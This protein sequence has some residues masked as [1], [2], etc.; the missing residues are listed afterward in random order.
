MAE[1]NELLEEA[2]GQCSALSDELD[3]AVAAINSMESKA[4]SLHEHAARGAESA[5]SGARQEA[6]SDLDALAEQA[7][8]LRTD[9]SDLVLHV[10]E[11]LEELQEQQGQ[12][13]EATNESMQAMGT[14][15]SDLGLKVQETQ[16]TIATQ[17]QEAGQ[18]IDAF[19]KAVEAAQTALGE[20]QAELG[21]ALD[22]F[23]ST[24]QEKTR[25]WVGALQTV[26]ADQTTAMVDMAN[27]ALVKHNDTMEALKTAFA[28]EAA[29]QVAASI[30][31]LQDSLELLGQRAGEH[32]TA[33]SARAED[34]LDRVRGALP[35]LEEL[36]AAFE[37]SSRLG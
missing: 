17:L 6:V 23:E 16:Q 5:L 21:T 4:D 28:T 31:P 3:T 18:A 37:Q 11:K 9:V 14:D 7:T 1:M 19:G 22:E 25:E 34:A 8:A 27:R 20:K 26:L 15:V 10:R 24:A 32:G 35:V 29:H 12:L 13:D 36:K 2:E 30:Q 33:I